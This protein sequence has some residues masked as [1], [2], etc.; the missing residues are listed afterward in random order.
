MTDNLTRP[1]AAA[2]CDLARRIAAYQEPQ[3][4]S[5]VA[6]VKAFPDLGSTKTYRRI[7]H[8]D[9]A[10]LDLEKQL[11]SY[12]AV[13]ARI[14]SLAAQRGSRDE[15]L[16]DDFTGL[17]QFKKALL[18]TMHERSPARLI[19][20]EGDTGTGKTSIR[21]VV[22]N[23]YGTRLLC[24]EATVAWGDSPM[25]MLGAIIKAT[26]SKDLPASQAERFDKVV[27]ILNAS[28][29]CLTIEEAHHL[30]VRLLNLLKS[31]LNL[32]AGEFATLAYPTLWAR[33]EKA[34]YHEVRQLT[35]NR[36]AERIRLQVDAADVRKFVS[37][38]VPLAEASL[39]GKFEAAL[40]ALSE[41]APRYGNYAFIR[42][43]CTRVV[44]LSEGTAGPSYE[45]FTGAI[46][47]EVNSR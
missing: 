8:D 47:A 31:L 5:D 21:R 13:W 36:L 35:G 18:D 23:K 30:G 34:A 22:Q 44:T 29:R 25:A 1:E 3:R 27:E 40:H 43:V 38:R 46:A 16:Y 37:R 6:L 11:A 28:R 14:E 41:K 45:Q 19:I 12:R 7:L 20:V 10:E 15:D 39:D 42:E 17:A 2:L 32:T 9:L 4:L 26:G 24:I 33:L